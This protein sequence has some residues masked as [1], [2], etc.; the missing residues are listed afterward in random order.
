MS[1]DEASYVVASKIRK[2]IVLRLN[3]PKTPT[4]LS[5]DLDVN[6]ANISRA[7]S[8]LEQKG[9]VVCLTPEQR[10]GRIYALTKKGEKIVNSIK[11]MEET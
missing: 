6:L 9:M 10:V 3:S 4:F 11:T 7:L 1:W 8:E 2:S 5:K